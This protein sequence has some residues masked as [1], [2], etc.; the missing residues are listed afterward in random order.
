MIPTT[1]QHIES[2]IYFKSDSSCIKQFMKGL[3][4]DIK[5]TLGKYYMIFLSVSPAL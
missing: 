1:Q 2:K 4:G 3:C 5:F